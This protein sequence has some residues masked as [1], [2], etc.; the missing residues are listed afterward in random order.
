MKKVLFVTVVMVCVLG[1]ALA[2]LAATR[3]K[4][5]L[6][7]G[8]VSAAKRSGGKYATVKPT[9]AQLAVIKKVFPKF[10]GVMKVKFVHV[11]SMSV[12]LQLM[13]KDV[14][15]INPVPVP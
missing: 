4:V 7:S 8:Q 2:A 12:A 14:V 10:S 13:G 3:C 15:S 1:L 11:R 9:A 6:N 5:T